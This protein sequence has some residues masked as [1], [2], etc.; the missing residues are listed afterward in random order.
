[1]WLLENRRN[2]ALDM[3]VMNYP[4]T[5]LVAAENVGVLPYQA[6]I[7]LESAGWGP[8]VS[9]DNKAV[10]AVEMIGAV[11]REAREAGIREIFYLSSDDRTDEFLRKHLNF[12]PVKAFRKRI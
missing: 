11:E 8:G 12:E 5:R 1:M 9:A 7:V 6:V 2:N 3:D 10:A 4:T